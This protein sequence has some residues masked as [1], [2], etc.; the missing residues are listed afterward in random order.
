MKVYEFANKVALPKEVMERIEFAVLYK[1]WSPF[2]TAQY[3]QFMFPNQ[4]NSLDVMALA[5][6]VRIKNERKVS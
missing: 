2:K 3:I 6:T 4:Y 5:D 1:G